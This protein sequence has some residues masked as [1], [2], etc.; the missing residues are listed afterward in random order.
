MYSVL[1]LD[2]IQATYTQNFGK[3][4]KKEWKINILVMANDSTSNSSDSSNQLIRWHAASAL[5]LTVWSEAEAEGWARAAMPDVE[6]R[7]RRTIVVKVVVLIIR[8][9]GLPTWFLAIFDV[10]RIPKATGLLILPN[11]EANTPLTPL[12]PLRKERSLYP[13]TFASAKTEELS[14]DL[15]KT[16]TP[17]L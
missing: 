5:G 13:S 17:L 7:R 14:T 9:T 10:N 8:H 15:Q 3:K 12:Q 2:T 4:S 1:N 6:C 16:H 11:K